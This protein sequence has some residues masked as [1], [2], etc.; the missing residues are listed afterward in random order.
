[1]IIHEMFEA[2]QGEGPYSGLPTYFIRTAG[3]SIGCEWC[4]TKQAWSKDSG[5]EMSVSEIVKKVKTEYN[6]KWVSITGGNPFEQKKLLKLVTSLYNNYYDILIEHPGVFID[7]SKEIRIL[8]EANAVSMDLKPPSATV[9]LKKIST[10]EIQEIILDVLNYITNCTTIYMKG[11]F[12]SI[13]DINFYIAETS[14]LEKLYNYTVGYL[15]YTNFNFYLQPCI[16][17]IITEKT[18]ELN[19][20]VMRCF[21]EGKFPPYV[22]LGTQLH[23]ILNFR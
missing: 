11:V 6:N 14:K 4:D 15:E 1:M 7:T 22:R 8:R 9:N 20:Y 16:E 10:Y 12:S 23:K 18:V 21:K 2:L 13:D 5:I 19:K 17:T 3:C